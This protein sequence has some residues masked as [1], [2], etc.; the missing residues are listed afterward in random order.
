M[1]VG[2]QLTDVNGT[3]T[4]TVTRLPDAAPLGGLGLT[5]MLGCAPCRCSAHWRLE[6]TAPLTR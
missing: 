6:I 1:G 5:L 4:V 2:S 3:V